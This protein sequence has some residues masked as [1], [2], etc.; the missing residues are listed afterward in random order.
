MKDRFIEIFNDNIKREGAGSLLSWME[1]SDFF[2]APASTR[3]HLSEPE[4]LVKH[5]VHVY[6]RLR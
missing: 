4:G 5:S 6:E 2:Q 3:Y 1:K